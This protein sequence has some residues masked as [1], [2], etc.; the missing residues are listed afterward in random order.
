MVI[1]YKRK[2][3]N[4]MMTIDKELVKKAMEESGFTPQLVDAVTHKGF[5]DDIMSQEDPDSKDIYILYGLLNIGE[6]K[7]NKQ[8]VSK[9]KTTGKK[10]NDKKRSIGCMQQINK[11]NIVSLYE[12][13]GYTA[14]TFAESCGCRTASN[15]SIMLSRGSCKWNTVLA[16]SKVLGCVPRDIIIGICN[17][18]NADIV[19]I[20]FP[21]ELTK[22]INEFTTE[23][24][25]N[26]FSK[27]GSKLSPSKIA[28]IMRIPVSL[29]KLAQVPS[30][31]CRL[32]ISAIQY[33]CD[34]GEMDLEDILAPSKDDI[35][36]VRI[37]DPTPSETE[38]MEE[39]LPKNPF[40]SSQEEKPKPAQGQKRFETAFE[41][42]LHNSAEAKKHQEYLE[43]QHK[44]ESIIRSKNQLLEIKKTEMMHNGM[45]SIDALIKITEML[46]QNPE[47]QDLFITLAALPDGKRQHAINALNTLITSLS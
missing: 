19:P 8:A 12:R 15:L 13:K 36:Q 30:S 40:A 25:G 47:V 27:L 3:G 37:T 24:N 6:K 20:S 18:T 45:I 21:K 2:R 28:K 46:Q 9:P 4:I 14:T 44:Q 35:K 16:M 39:A 33:L 22:N 5:Y 26:N 17:A 11:K 41:E 31:K 1:K 23:V 7:P 38:N 42:F 34:S 32:P 29:V 43:G 10:P